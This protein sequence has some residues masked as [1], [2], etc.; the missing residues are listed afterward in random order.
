MESLP[1]DQTE[2]FDVVVAGAGPAGSSIAILLARIGHR[3]LVLE[4][5]RFPRFHVGEGLLPALWPLWDHLGVTEEIMNAGFVVKRGANFGIFESPEDVTLLAAEFPQYF[6]RPETFHVER[7]RFDELLLNHARRQGA[8]VREQWT[9]ADVI[10]DDGQAVGVIAGPNGEVPHEIRARVVVDATGRN[11]L[12]SRKLGLRKPDPALNKTS[13]FA[14]FAGA[15]RPPST[16]PRFPDSVVTDI[17]TMEGGWFWYIPLSNDIVSVGAVVD[18]RYAPH[19]K[20]PQNRFD[21]AVT[22]CPRIQGWLGGAKQVSEMHTISNISYL[23]E[24]FVG[25]GY[26]MIGDASMFVDPIFSAGV[27]I[28]IRGAA[29]AAECIADALAH[30][31]VSAAR[32]QPYEDRIRIPMKK[33]FSMIYNWYSILDKK[34]TANNMFVRARRIPILRERL[35]VFFSGR[36][37][38]VDFES[39]MQ[40]A[41]SGELV[42]QP[43]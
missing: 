20:G 30:D 36:Y 2:A 1:K 29:F 7:A 12:M 27:T 26:V 39:I 18:A 19:I 6:Q 4:K 42:L 43:A 40:A 38:K 25:D 22:T 10:M 21:H 34:D 15:H 8:V 24:S 13:H 9:V 17:H 33:I 11:C 37:D 41:E 16:D 32:L 3:V 31:D 5:E 14:H 23:N 35:I 28:A